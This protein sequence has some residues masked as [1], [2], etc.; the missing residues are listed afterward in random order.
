MA[1]RNDIF[2]ADF[3]E[4][5]YWWEAASP[6]DAGNLNLPSSADVLVVGGGYTGLNAAL[7]LARAGRS[8]VVC[9][10]HLFGHG[11]SSR[12]GG[13]VSA[14]INLGKGIAG[15]P[16]EQVNRADGV[17]LVEALMR[18][19]DAAYDL[20]GELISRESIDCHY[21][22]Y[23]RMVGAFTPAHFRK[24]PEQAERINRLTDAGASVISRSQLGDEMASTFYHGGLV[25]E[26]AAKLH[27]ALYLAGLR[28]A[29]VRAGAVLCAHTPVLRVDGE[30]GEFVVLTSKGEIRAADVVIGTNGYTGGLTPQLCRQIVPASS[31]II[32]TEELP[33]A[34]VQSLIPKGRT[35]SDTPR[36]LHYYRQ[37]P[38][39]K[40]IIFGGRARFTD[41]GPRTRA[42]LLHKSMS[43]RFP[44]LTDAK[45][46]HSWTGLLAFTA[47][48]VPHVGQYRGMHYAMGCNG[49]GVAMMTYLGNLMGRRIL[50]GNDTHSA[51]LGRAHSPVPVPGYN[52]N[53]WFL[54]LVGGWYR[55]RDR[56]DRWYGDLTAR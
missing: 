33:E 11:A 13:A 45:V 43:E 36:I 37:S 3:C 17:A 27:P 5:P 4:T 15:G 21:Q 53:P 14:G 52:G 30:Q 16:G 40:R 6:D 22:Q 28:A 7:E 54:P 38:D 10:A 55:W 26:R 42:Q 46:T 49:S 12:N 9:E 29:A 1:I 48:S 47:D 50:R 41:V 31:H 34:L 2:A 20:V 24:F 56:I 32:A 51:Y 19:S 39:G 8:V 18:E 25:I 44:Q 23:G 35:L